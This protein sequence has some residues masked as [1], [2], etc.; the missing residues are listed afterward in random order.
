MRTPFSLRT[1][2][3][4]RLLVA[5]LVVFGA[6]ASHADDGLDAIVRARVAAYESG[7]D[8]AARASRAD[9]LLETVGE[10]LARY[11]MP[12]GALTLPDGLGAV[13]EDFVR[14]VLSLAT[15]AA[16]ER[17]DERIRSQ[18][19]ATA[20]QQLIPHADDE[21]GDLSFF[22]AL[23]SQARIPI[24]AADVDALQRFALDWML[25]DVMIGEQRVN[26]PLQLDEEAAASLADG[27]AGHAVLVLRLAGNAARRSEVDPFLTGDHLALGAREISSL[28]RLDAKA[29]DRAVPEAAATGAADTG[30]GSATDGAGDEAARRLLERYYAAWSRSPDPPLEMVAFAGS[31]ANAGRPEIARSWYE[32]ILARHPDYDGAHYGMGM[33]LLRSGQPDEARAHFERVVAA[34]SSGFEPYAQLQLGNMANRRGDRVAAF[35]H[36]QRAVETGPYLVTAR[37]NYAMALRLRGRT[38]EAREQLE[39]AARRDPDLPVPHLQLGV[40]LEE[41]GRYE[42]AAAR[43]QRVLEL[44]PGNPMALYRLGMESERTGHPKEAASYYE[45]A[46]RGAE[47]TGNKALAAQIRRRLKAH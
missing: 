28:A 29:A 23:A 34:G 24:A 42:E 38:E 17:G 45:R 39:E 18:D 35:E 4:A 27:V 43:Y 8:D 1:R 14:A 25:L 16:R 33:L 31:M 46:L 13:S 12:P 2:A 26:L 3:A 41:Q 7:L 10:R 22:P 6:A 37:V 15:G 11:A 19:V 21:N 5:C 30:G 44:D 9:R 20:L 36:Y 47:R 32:R 40:M